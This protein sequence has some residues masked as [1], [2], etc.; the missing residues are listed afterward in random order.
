[1]V[2]AAK[3]RIGLHLPTVDGFGTGRCDI[4]PMAKAADDAGFDSAWVGD[5]LTFTSPVI[6]AFIAAATAAACSQRVSIGFSVLIAG[7][8][9]P[10]WLA[11]Q[12]TSLQF[13][14]G[15][16]L[17]VGLGI[18]GEFASDWEAAGVPQK[19]RATRT[20]ALLEVLPDLLAGK[21][22]HLPQPW[23]LDVA[24]LT[25][26]G[27]VP[28][29]WIGGRKD[30]ALRRAVRNNAGWLGLWMDKPVLEERIRRLDEIAGEHGAAR[31]RVALEVLVHPTRNDDGE[32][33]MRRFMEQVYGLPFE[34]IARYTFGG[35][36]ESI[37][38]RLIE[39]VGAGV[40][41]L[42]INPAMESPLS[43]VDDLAEIRSRVDAAVNAGR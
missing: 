22:A 25:P 4:G 28:P 32:A 42:I 27:E 3:K 29:L 2:D 14:S 35:S 19:Q 36:P 16:R 1:M 10:A 33:S 41:E 5:H 20:D 8:R 13:V 6:E 39:L 23:D 18:G 26:G 15:G 40:D 34:R 30:P 9:Q 12:L 7:L 21:P 38:H 37:A 31:P 11:K 24:P 43:A 17:H